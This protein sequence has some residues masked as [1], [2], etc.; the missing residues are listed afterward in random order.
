MVCSVSSEALLMHKMVFTP[1]RA[2]VERI[3]LQQ[4]AAFSPDTWGG[5]LTTDDGTCDNTISLKLELSPQG[6]RSGGLQ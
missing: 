6:V 2:R 5:W 4:H 1:E 3:T